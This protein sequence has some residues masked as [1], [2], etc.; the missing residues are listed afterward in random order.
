MKLITPFKY[1]IVAP[2]IPKRIKPWVRE[3]VLAHS[4]RHDLFPVPERDIFPQ[5]IRPGDTVIDIGANIGAYTTH[6]SELADE[7][8]TVLAFEPVQATYDI[9][10]RATKHLDNVTRVHGALSDH[11][12]KEHIRLLK[13]DET[14]GETSLFK[15]TLEPIW[16]GDSTKDV[17]ELVTVKK[18]DN[19]TFRKPSFIKCDAEG[20]DWAVIQGAH[21]T[22]ERWRPVWLVE[23]MVKPEDSPI[24][25]YFTGMDYVCCIQRKGGLV[26]TR[27]PGELSCT[28]NYF[29]I[30]R[31]M[32]I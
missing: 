30:P 14:V 8:G 32:R 6:F 1:N 4:V 17:T 25:K 3:R 21:L 16:L 10:F 19:H 24:L 9:L 29:F 23:I 18:L 7:D 5:F 27:T 12:G 22:T 31:E 15:S 26:S 20:H 2:L 28:N 11:E 13:A